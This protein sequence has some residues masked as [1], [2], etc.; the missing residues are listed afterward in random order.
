M[1]NGADATPLVAIVTPVYNG[2]AYLAATMECV[3]ALD[4]PRLV[5]VILDNASTDRSPEIISRYRNGRVPLLTARNE[6]I[7]PKIENFNS[8]LGLVPR[9]ARYFRLLCADDTMAPNA[10]TRKVE[11]A[12]RDPAIG[13]VGCLCRTD[14]LRGNT[15][16]KDREVFDGK[17]IARGLLLSENDVL[18]GTEVL[19]RLTKLEGRPWFYDAT[20]VGASDTD[21]STRNQS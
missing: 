5:H 4:Y 1:I 8:A 10:I 18:H 12:E 16:P 11:V 15:L 6:N 3:Q 14:I 9:E 7:I 20:L 17:E 2:E 21:A 19:I 13:L